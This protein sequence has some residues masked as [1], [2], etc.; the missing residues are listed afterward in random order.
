MKKWFTVQNAASDP[1][2][3]VMIYD[4]IGKDW[5]SDNGIAAKDFAESLKAIPMDKEIRCR[6][7]SPGGN[8]WDGMAIYSMLNARREKVTCLVDGLAGSIASVIACA[9]SKT[10]MP[11]NALMMIHNPKSSCDGDA[12]AMRQMADK[13]DAHAKAIASVYSAKTGKSEAEILALMDKETWM[14]GIEAKADRFCD[15]TEGHA[16]MACATFDFSRFRH[17]PERLLGIPNNQAPNVGAQTT[18]IMTR[19]Q[20]TALLQRAGVQVANDASDAWLIE[21][22]TKLAEPKPPAQNSAPQNIAD[23]QA[24]VMAINAQLA[25]ERRLRIESLVQDLVDDCRVTAAEKPKAVARAVADITYLDELRTRPQTLPGASPLNGGITL[26]GEDVRNITKELTLHTSAGKQGESLVQN[27]LERGQAF[28]RVWAK[29]RE[30]MI[31][32]LNTTAHSID[33][34]LKRVAILNDTIRAFAIRLLPLRQFATVFSNVPLQGT[35]EIVVPYFPL[36]AAASVDWN[37]ANGYVFTGQTNTQ[38]RKITVNKRKYQ[39]LDYSST[40]FRRQPY[41]DAVRLGAM[42]FEK[43]A[44][45]I[46]R[47]VLSLITA[48]NFGAAAKTEAITTLSSDDIIDIRD[49]C[50]K[51]NW[52]DMGR[53]LI[54]DSS[55]DT[56]LQKDSAYKLA[57]N[58]GTTQVIQEGRLPKLSGFDYSWMPNF[59]DNGE[60]LVGIAAFM[61]GILA[62]FCPIDPTPDVRAQLTAYDIVT[63][64]QTGISA[65]YRRWGL[66]QTDHSYEVIEGAYG[67]A[68]GEAAAIKRIVTP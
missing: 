32:V 36:Q 2:A 55:V 29:E 61:S 40:D 27:A 11:S 23:L 53:S 50:N 28:S 46:L 62:A 48:A 68:P 19:Q 24:Q 5:F 21:Q 15:E 41:F 45:D 34:N 26:V 56:I 58:I 49:V 4:Q 59:P 57:L 3:E 20:M 1:V 9:G 63:D 13:L 12:A 16:V 18:E 65:N 66:A 8:V 64:A 44:I 35:D 37:E 22:L 7:N 14:S 38:S 54:V 6:I 51:A 39:P 60:K 31:P 33:A 10:I 25:D 42:N 17:V 47:D 30:R 52:P 43:L 67:F